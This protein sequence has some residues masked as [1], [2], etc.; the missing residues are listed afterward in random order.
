MFAEESGRVPGVWNPEGM[1]DEPKAAEPGGG[2][3][4]CLH[5]LRG[6]TELDTC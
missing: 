5:T 3:E 1:P 4:V 6:L 2:R